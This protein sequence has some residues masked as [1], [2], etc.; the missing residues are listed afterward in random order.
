ME[1]SIP[2]RCLLSCRRGRIWKLSYHCGVLRPR[3]SLFGF[4][5]LSKW[6]VVLLKCQNL[7]YDD[8]LG[9]ASDDWGWRAGW[10]RPSAYEFSFD[11]SRLNIPCCRCSAKESYE[12]SSA[13]LSCLS[14]SKNI[15]TLS[16]YQT[17]ESFET[18]GPL[19]TYL[20]HPHIDPLGNS[21]LASR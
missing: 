10:S 2:L 8:V 11:L 4:C 17:L 13:C 21:A 9:I 1:A 7:L 12:K 19:N 20:P 18:V 6:T 16:S 14:L 15:G 5:R 3:S